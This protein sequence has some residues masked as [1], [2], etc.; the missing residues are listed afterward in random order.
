MLTLMDVDGD[1]TVDFE[2]F[3]MIMEYIKE[4]KGKYGEIRLKTLFNL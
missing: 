2:E 4:C 3:C 1:R